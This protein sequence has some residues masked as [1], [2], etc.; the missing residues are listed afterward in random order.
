MAFPS[1]YPS[2]MSNNTTSEAKF[3]MAIYSAQLAPTA[4]APTTVIFILT[5]FRLNP[6]N[7]AFGPKKGG[8]R[9]PISHPMA[10]IKFHEDQKPGTRPGTNAAP[11]TTS[12]PYISHRPIWNPWPGPKKQLGRALGL[13]RKQALHRK[14]G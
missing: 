7:K 14:R 10:P 5:R 3:F 8:V 2:L 13:L 12:R 6:K 11:T 9:G 1:T 4:P